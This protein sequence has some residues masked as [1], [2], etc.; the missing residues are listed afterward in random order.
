LDRGGCARFK[1]TLPDATWSLDELNI[2]SEGDDVVGED[3]ISRTAS[4]ARIDYA[5][6]ADK[7]PI[8]TIAKEINI[9]L[10]CSKAIKVT[11]MYACD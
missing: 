4:L 6:L 11:K 3:E 8:K 1:Y 9:I 10:N 5:T 2:L 7:V